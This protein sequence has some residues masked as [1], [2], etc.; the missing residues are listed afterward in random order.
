MQGELPLFH[1]AALRVR[2]T[3]ASFSPLPCTGAPKHN[4]ARHGEN[5]PSYEGV[6]QWRK[7]AARQANQREPQGC[8][9]K[10]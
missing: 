2:W 10:G 4:L 3:R 7:G 1:A 8:D 9:K 5:T 6:G